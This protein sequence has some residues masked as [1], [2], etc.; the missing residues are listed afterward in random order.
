MK[1]KD[2][3][4]RVMLKGLSAAVALPWLEAMGPMA[5]WAADAVPAKTAPNRMASTASE[6][7]PKA[8]I[9]M[10][11]TSSSIALILAMR[12]SPDIPGIR[13]SVITTAGEFCSK[14]FSPFSPSVA[15][16]TL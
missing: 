15:V 10:T 16:M 2:L 12:S 4:R 13:I 6:I 9:S 8:V 11:G 14:A 7:V 5:S 1:R 3:S